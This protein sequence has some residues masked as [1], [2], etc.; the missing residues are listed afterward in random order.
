[1]LRIIRSLLIVLVIVGGLAMHLRNDQPVLFDYYLGNAE[2]PLSL[3]L[4]FTLIAGAILG[5]LACMPRIL[6]I[7]KEKRALLARIRVIEKELDNLR[8]IPARN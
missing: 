2:V 6:R 1:M 8:V 5:G 3:L 4:I 7:R